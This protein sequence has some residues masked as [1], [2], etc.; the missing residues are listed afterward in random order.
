MKTLGRTH[1]G[2]SQSLN[3]LGY[4]NA[5]KQESDSIASGHPMSP[6]CGI[7]PPLVEGASQVIS[8]N[9]VRSTL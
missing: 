4:W 2:N 7:V 6:P 9:L 3:R 5:Q 8:V 1:H